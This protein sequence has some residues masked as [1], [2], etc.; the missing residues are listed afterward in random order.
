MKRV[1]LL[2]NT[3]KASPGAHLIGRRAP[4]VLH[5]LA[6]SILLTFL[7]ATITSVSVNAQTTPP[8]PSLVDASLAVRRV[9]S[10]F[11]TPIQ[12]AFLGSND[13]LVLEKNTGKVVRVT[14]GAIQNT[15]LDLPVNFGSERGLLGIALHPN[16]PATPWV[17]LYWVESPSGVDTNNLA[18]LSS[19]FRSKNALLRNRVDRFVWNGST[20][21]HDLNLIRLRTYQADAGQPLRGNHDGGVIRFGPDGKL[22]III[23]DLGRRGLMQNIQTGFGPNNRD[24]QF[25][26]PEPDN[27]HLSGVILRLNDDGSTPV[28]NPFYAVGAMM[29]GEVGANI[30]KTFAYGVRNSFGMDFDPIAGHLW[31][32]ENGDDSFDE[33]NRVVPGFN[34]G[35][36]QII[37]PVSRIAEFKAIETDRTAPQ[38]FAPNGYFGLQQ[39]RWSPTLIADT[40]AEA[41]SRLY[42]LP[43]SRYRDPK[44][45][46][47]FAVAPAAVGFLNS[48]ALGERYY[49]DLFV[50]ES[51]PFLEGGYLFR[52]NLTRNRLNFS[53]GDSR[54]RDLVADNATKYGITESES[55][56]FGRN[57]GTVTDIQTGPNGN[58]YVVSI[59]NPAFGPGA[60]YEIFRP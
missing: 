10:G 13:F 43:G 23:G 34:G 18:Q 6:A 41:L 60:I 25:G 24:D 54:I 37:G 30:Q 3:G 55:L 11:V 4:A 17:Y 44:F 45:S 5:R 50:G 27:T 58:L 40:P 53:L 52:F 14:D 49:S 19:I 59:N 26:G 39:I 56:L 29:G 35:W 9:A 36:T 31:T 1:R 16:F 32:A 2:F 51:T 46:W 57:F 38:P 48:R 22:H 12:M 20:L 33:I 42:T 7:A 28:D 21:T 8:E 47:K 15:V